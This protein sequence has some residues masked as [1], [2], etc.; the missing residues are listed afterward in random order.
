MKHLAAI[1]AGIVLAFSVVEKSI[2]ET[3]D[4]ERVEQRLPEDSSRLR[5]TSQSTIAVP[6]DSNQEFDAAFF[7]EFALVSVSIEGM[8]AIDPAQANAC[9]KDIIGTL[10]GAADLVSITQCI[11]QLYRDEGFFLS[12]AIVPQQE[13]KDGALRIRAIEGYVAAIAPTGIDQVMADAQFSATLKERPVK[14]STFE[15]DL[16]L[17]SDRPGLRVESSQLIVDQ[18]DLARYTFK[19]ATTVNFVSWRIF[20]DNRGTEAT[21]PDQAFVSVAWNSI[22]GENDRLAASLF[23]APSDPHEL[24]YADLNYSHGWAAGSLWT[25]TGMSLTRSDDGSLPPSQFSISSTDRIYARLSAP[26]IRSRRQSLWAAATYDMRDTESLSSGGNHTR[27]S[28]RVLRGSLSYTL[29]QGAI[30][31]GITLEASHGLGALGASENGDAALSRADA[32]PQFA[33]LRMD[34]SSTLSLTDRWGLALT[35]AAQF[36]DGALTGSEEFG[37]GGARFGRGFDYSEISG[38]H[39]IAAALELRWALNPF[40]E[41]IRTVQFYSF[42]DAGG[43]WNTRLDPGAATWSSL[44]SA[45][46]GVRASFFQGLLLTLEL[47]QPLCCDQP[48]KGNFNPRFFVSLTAGW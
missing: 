35:T 28:A 43:V 11:T 4:L 1:G 46:A 7:P 2:A 45:G 36:A 47:A 34:T 41:S 5:G 14:L 12:R 15:R 6:V 9:A 27:E 48:S 20:A 30:R 44:A 38:D 13:V 23:T 22:F 25:E 37:V 32:R 29:V 31:T 21:G 19:V 10:A 16:L 40:S 17:L 33:K 8:H 24:L 3:D 39:G 18:Y 26:L 42:V